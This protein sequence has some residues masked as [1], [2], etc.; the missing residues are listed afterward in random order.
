MALKIPKNL[1]GGRSFD[2]TFA[3]APIRK[4]QVWRKAGPVGAVEIL[5]VMLPG[6]P[7]YDGGAPG[8]SVRTTQLGAR[9][10]SWGRKTWFWPGTER[11]LMQ[12]LKNDGYA[13]ASGQ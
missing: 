12:K 6:E 5:R 2:A 4:G 8:I 1:P 11:Q 7:E 10:V 3:P 13:L 9:S